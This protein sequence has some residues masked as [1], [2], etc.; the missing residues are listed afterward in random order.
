MRNVIASVST[1][2]W[3]PYLEKASST[4]AAKARCVQQ[5]DV[6]V[7]CYLADAASQLHIHSLASGKQQQPVA[8][9]GIGSVTQFAGRRE[10][11]ECFFAFSSYTEPGAI[12]RY[13]GS[14]C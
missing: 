13:A 4:K 7:A 10:D 14:A 9:P 11:S 2:S 8:L 12:Y 5:G 1:D 6:L 3:S